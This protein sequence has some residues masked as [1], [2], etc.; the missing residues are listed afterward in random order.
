MRI[1]LNEEQFKKLMHYYF[2]DYVVNVRPVIIEDHY[3]IISDV[4]LEFI[5]KTDN[6]KYILDS[7][8]LKEK[9]NVILKNNHIMVDDIKFN[10]M[11]LNGNIFFQNV[12]VVI[13]DKVYVKKY[14]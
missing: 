2:K 11:Y 13:Q 7:E 14:N 1:T 9:S 12:E 5:N 3:E 6:T 4:I 10:T 8:N